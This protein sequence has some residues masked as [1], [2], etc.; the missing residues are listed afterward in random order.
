MLDTVPLVLQG[1]GHY[2]LLAIMNIVVTEQFVGLGK[3]R[4][5]SR[6]QDFL[7]SNLN[8]LSFLLWWLPPGGDQVSD[9]GRQ[10]GLSVQ[11]LQGEGF[12]FTYILYN[13]LYIYYSYYILCDIYDILQVLSQCKCSPF[14][15]R[16]YYGKRVNYSLSFITIII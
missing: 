9:G 6:C 7:I 5:Q 10:S 8:F 4:H 14:S 13:I 12:L 15:L 1:E 16:S 11:G 2:K 3:A